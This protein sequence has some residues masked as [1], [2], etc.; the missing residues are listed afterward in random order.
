M[1]INRHYAVTA[2]SLAALLSVASCKTTEAPIVGPVVD[3]LTG[4]HNATEARLSTAASNAL[5]EGKADEAM[6]HY[7]RLY[8]NNAFDQT[9]ALNYAQLLRRTGKAQR[10]QAVL[11]PFMESRMRRRL[12][13]DLDPI[14][15]NE[16]A[17]INIE[18]GNFDVAKEYLKKVLDDKK[19]THLH[20]DAHNLQGVILDGEDR[21]EEAEQSFRTA[22]DSWKG[23]PT[24]V[25]NNLGLCLASQGRFDESLT[26]LRQALVMAP[27]KKAIANNIE[28]VT[29]L[30]KAVAPAGKSKKKKK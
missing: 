27:D 11:A 12:K 2:I 20:A 6:A 5:A 13:M 1:K 21:H 9:I 7:E 3:S 17:A 4:M 14:L 15:F 19:A 28:M 23:D 8:A 26:T 10:A 25:M 16:Y 29:G 22:L 18:L 24:S 30:K